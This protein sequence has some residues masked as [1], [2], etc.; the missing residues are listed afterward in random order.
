MKQDDRN[1]TPLAP[2]PDERR[3]ASPS[4]S[5]RSAGVVLI[6]THCHLD[7]DRFDDDR[8]AVLA[9]AAENG[10]SAIIIPGVNLSSSK[11]AVALADQFESV[12]AAV[13]IHPTATDELDQAAV[14]TLH[15]MAQHPKVVAIGEIGL[16]YYWPNQPDRRWP[17]AS[18]QTQR[19]AFRRQLDL[20]AELSLPV[21]IH[22][23]EAHTDVM[24]GLEDS[25]GVSGVLHSFSG[26]LD[27]A[28]WAVDLGFYV[29]ITGPVTYK[30]SHDMKTVAR[31]IDFE[32]LLIETDAPFLAPSP[33]RGKRNE[34]ANVRYVA[35]EIA[36]LRECGLSAV[37]QRTT[38]NAQTLFQRL[39]QL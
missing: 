33:Y 31:Q 11:A 15:E 23:R 25:K 9:R 13:G 17:C 8:T 28:E 7:F 5:A 30:K 18:P 26:D 35:Q 22:D 12:Y 2:Q 39:Y 32:R 20:A 4:P 19:K 3:D 29:G 10:V 24:I 38:A 37:A 36:Q 16:D 21:I 27:L 34:P 1:K 14:R 6:D